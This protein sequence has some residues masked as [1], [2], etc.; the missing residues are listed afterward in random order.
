MKAMVVTTTTV[1][2]SM[3]TMMSWDADPEDVNGEK[4]FTKTEFQFNAGVSCLHTHF[5]F[6]CSTFVW[7][8]IREFFPPDEGGIILNHCCYVKLGVET[9]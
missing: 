8:V 2:A 3:V 5:V 1:T 6:V 9:E 4:P 7:F